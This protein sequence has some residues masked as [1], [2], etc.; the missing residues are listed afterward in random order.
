MPKTLGKIVIGQ[1]A[2]CPDG[3]GRVSGFC[4]QYPEQWIEVSTY[5]NNSMCHWS[6]SNVQLIPLP[7]AETS[8]HKDYRANLV[9]RLVGCAEFRD[10][11]L[12][13]TVSVGSDLGHGYSRKVSA[14]HGY[15]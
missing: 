4:D 5:Y 14:R 15:F 8:R 6:P 12:N 3:L 13:G 9:R 10:E 1:E 7:T 11:V 2:I